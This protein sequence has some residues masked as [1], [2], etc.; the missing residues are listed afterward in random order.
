MIQELISDGCLEV[1]KEQAAINN[2][3]ELFDIANRTF[4]A[5]GKHI[6]IIDLAEFESLVIATNLNSEAYVVDERTIRLLIENPMLIATILKDR[7]HSKIDVNYE[8]LEAIKNKFGNVKIIRSVELMLVAYKLRLFDGLINQRA[9]KNS[10]LELLDGLLW[11]LKLHGC[12]I[13][14][15]EI[16]EILNSNMARG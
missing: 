1:F 16:Q 9:I 11:A 2:Y 5:K 14:D 13:S 12:S 4:I 8:N 10:R 7:L 3:Q 6:K 15:N